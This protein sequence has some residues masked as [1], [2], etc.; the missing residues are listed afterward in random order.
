MR[1]NKRAQNNG[2]YL[3]PSSLT[4]LA[5]A[6]MNNTS[7]I[8]PDAAYPQKLWITLWKKWGNQTKSA[9]NKG[10]A[11]KCLYRSQNVIFLFFQRVIIQI[12]Q[13]EIFD[14][15]PAADN[16]QPILAVNNNPSV[17]EFRLHYCDIQPLELPPWSVF[18]HRCACRFSGVP[19]FVTMRVRSTLS[20]RP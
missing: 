3:I 11:L 10:S 15:I 8:N 17:Y 1:C 14:E 6:K 19:N 18:A 2:M 16:A 7:K 20:R 5:D 12:W 9:A 4:M 13:T